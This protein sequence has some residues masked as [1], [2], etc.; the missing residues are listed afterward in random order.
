MLDAAPRGPLAAGARRANDAAAP[1][2]ADGATARALL[3]A[4][5]GCGVGRSYATAAPPSDAL[6]GLFTFDA[7]AITSYEFGGDSCGE[8][9]P[10]AAA[11]EAG[12]R[13]DQVE[14]ELRH[15][16]HK[17]QGVCLSLHERLAALEG[18]ARRPP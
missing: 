3:C 13:L 11:A 4:A 12:G 14:R 10:A 15:E 5:C 18:A 7:E 6:V 2:A 17:V 9:P 1:R 8:C 16:L